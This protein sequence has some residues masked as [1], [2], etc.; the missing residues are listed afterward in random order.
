[1][2]RKKLRG[3][4]SSEGKG[5]SAKPSEETELGAKG[6]RRAGG[7]EGHFNRTGEVSASLPTQKQ[8]A[9]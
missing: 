5:T 7:K 1:V 9:P 6:S 3:L 2:N 4:D 8:R